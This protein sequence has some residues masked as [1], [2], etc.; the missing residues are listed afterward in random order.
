MTD[1]WLAQL[2]RWHDFYVI[3]GSAAAGL[4][5]LMFVVVSLST[6]AIVR[7]REKGTRAFVTPT[8][9][10]FTTVLIE[11]AVLTVPTMTVAVLGSLLT[12]GGVAAMIYLFCTRSHRVWKEQELDREDWIWYI[13]L[14][15]LGYLFI[16]ATGTLIWMRALLGLE[17][18]AATA[19]LFLIIGIRNSWDLVVWMTQR[20]VEE[21]ATAGKIPGAAPDANDR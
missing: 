5:G 6:E 8:A 21:R 3:T 10:Y 15:Y 19:L 4:T 1:S 12:V 20:R 2:D 16:V 11:A 13:G 17:M 14:P 7:Q 9:V 18:L